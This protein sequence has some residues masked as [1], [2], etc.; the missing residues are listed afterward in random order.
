M[1]IPISEMTEQQ[2]KK[3]LTLIVDKLDELDC[4]DYF[5]TEGWKHQFGLED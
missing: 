2:A 1:D 5:G 3:M 4:E